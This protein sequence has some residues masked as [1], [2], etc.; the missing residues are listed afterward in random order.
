MSIDLVTFRKY[1]ENDFYL[2]SQSKI[3]LA[4]SGGVDSMCLAL[5][6]QQ[7]GFRF[8]CLIVD[9]GLRHS[10][11]AEALDTQR[12][13]AHNDIE[14]H[15]IQWQLF[16]PHRK[17]NNLHNTARSAR[18][19]LMIEYC[20]QR[21]IN[22]LMFAHNKNDQAENVLI[23]IARGTGID[24]IAEIK[25]DVMKDGVRILRPLLRYNRFQIKSTLQLYN[26]SWIEDSSNEDMRFV[27]T[28]MRDLLRTHDRDLSIDRI[29]LLS[30]NASRVKDYLHH[31]TLECF[32]R[33]VRTDELGIIYLDHT[34]FLREHEEIQLRILSRIMR[35]INRCAHTIRLESLLNLLQNI[36][37]DCFEGATLHGCEIIKKQNEFLFIRE[38]KCLTAKPI[39]PYE[40]T[41]I[42]D[43]RFTLQ[44]RPSS[45]LAYSIRA[46]NA[47]DWRI[48]KITLA[49]EQADIPFKIRSTLPVID[50]D[51][52]IVAC[53]SLKW[54]ERIFHIDHNDYHLNDA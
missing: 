10:S 44:I 6:M 7:V 50:S 9:H 49:K 46:M 25:N 39:A 52:G 30:R 4:V 8:V 18:Y 54:G 12:N 34:L 20:K 22:I 42:W 45:S 28:R 40:Q 43:H 48:I 29:C 33:L 17:I 21:N 24:G 5:L 31:Q 32:S 19:S 36:K 3:A 38:V 51:N 2:S 41:I 26:W 35:S 27:R 53:P 14:A 11:N 13:L 1:L 47:E 16:D 15:V 37:S 23:R